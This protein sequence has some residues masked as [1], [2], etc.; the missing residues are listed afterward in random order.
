MDKNEYNDDYEII[1]TN[2]NKVSKVF[3]G[4]KLFLNNLVDKII[5]IPNFARDILKSNNDSTRDFNEFLK[6]D[7]NTV[8]MIIREKIESGNYTDEQL[9]E[10]LD[11]TQKFTQQS[12]RVL[13]K[14]NK[15]N[16]ELLMIVAGS[17]V[18]IITAMLNNN[19]KA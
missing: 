17:V 13:D 5:E 2:E 8:D 1:N 4:S 9:N 12:E 15:H 19:N 14:L 10:L 3:N 6:Q 18:A 11:R 16:K 7:K